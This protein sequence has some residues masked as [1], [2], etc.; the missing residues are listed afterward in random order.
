LERVRW[1]VY[2]LNMKIDGFTE[3]Y[4][5]DT[6]E[7]QS[8]AAGMEIWTAPDGRRIFNVTENEAPTG[9]YAAFVRPRFTESSPAA[10]PSASD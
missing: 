8:Q 2:D 1:K 5:R 3:I 4:F 6:A 9:E 7:F 10:A